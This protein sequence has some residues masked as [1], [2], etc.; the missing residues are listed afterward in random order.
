[1]IVRALLK[2]LLA[3]LC[4]QKAEGVRLDAAISDNFAALG[5][6]RR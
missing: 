4:G 6:L 1:M 2:R 3:E 5:S